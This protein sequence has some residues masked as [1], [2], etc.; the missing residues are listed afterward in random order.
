M[1][2]DTKPLPENEFQKYRKET[3]PHDQEKFIPGLQGWYNF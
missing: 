2:R 3:I 1:N